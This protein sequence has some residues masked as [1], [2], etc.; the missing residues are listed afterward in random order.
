MGD[1]PINPVIQSVDS[2]VEGA[3]DNVVQ[4]GLKDVETAVAAQPDSLEKS[5][6]TVAINLTAE[7]AKPFISYVNHLIETG[8]IDAGHFLVGV[9]NKLESGFSS[10]FKKI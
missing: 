8:V 5:A 7:E 6:E 3:V 9:K 10:L 1:Q 2:K 4:D